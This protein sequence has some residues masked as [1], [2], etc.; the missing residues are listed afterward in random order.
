MI[1]IR[2]GDWN[3]PNGITDHKTAPWPR[4]VPRPGAWI[5]PSVL[6]AW[7][8]VA[9]SRL[10]ARFGAEDREVQARR[11]V[12]SLQ[13]DIDHRVG[14]EGGPAGGI[15]TIIAS[16]PTVG[17]R[18]SDGLHWRTLDAIPQRGATMGSVSA[19]GRLPGGGG[20][21]FEG[22]AAP[23]GGWMPV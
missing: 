19:Y 23:T 8:R 17:E 6:T 13:L 7:Q 14:L 9:E 5:G 11:D 21:H 18:R 15:G 20:W 2:M 16:D 1:R 22:A 10:K 4:P 3:G 12:A